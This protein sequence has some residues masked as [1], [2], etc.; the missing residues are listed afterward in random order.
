MGGKQRARRV[1][2]ARVAT[3]A[4]NKYRKVVEDAYD[5]LL[6][7]QARMPSQAMPF[8]DPVIAEF[9][10]LIALDTKGWREKVQKD[11]QARMDGLE[12]ER[13]HNSNAAQECYDKAREERREAERLNAE[14]ANMRREM[15]TEA[16]EGWRPSRYFKQVSKLVFLD[17]VLKGAG[18]NDGYESGKNWCASVMAGGNSLLVSQCFTTPE[19]AMDAAQAMFDEFVGKE[20]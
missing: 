5:W 11:D 13:E 6:A 7:K 10:K 20:E 15:G 16:R 19:E 9:E 12:R 1:S 2:P 8:I 4:A 18:F 17:V 3:V 14:T